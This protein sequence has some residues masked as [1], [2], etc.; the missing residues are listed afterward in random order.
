[1]IFGE[2]VMSKDKYYVAAKVSAHSTQPSALLV[3]LSILMLV[4]TV[5]RNSNLPLMNEMANVPTPRY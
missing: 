5:M 1:M 4:L 2:T 3:A